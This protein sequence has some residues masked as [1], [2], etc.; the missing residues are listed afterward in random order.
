MK[1]AS[2]I[3]DAMGAVKLN[4]LA[5][6]WQV[7][8]ISVILSEVVV[9]AA[10]D[11]AVEGPRVCLNYAEAIQGVS[12]R[13]AMR[14]RRKRLD[15]AFSTNAVQRSFDYGTASHREAVPSLRMTNLFHMMVFLFCLRFFG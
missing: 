8:H 15:A 12:S 11:Y 5:G 1:S 3:V 6:S 10:D 13:H 9:R 4:G 7:S 14:S 2:S